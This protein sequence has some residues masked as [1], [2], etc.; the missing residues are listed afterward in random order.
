LLQSVGFEVLRFTNLDVFNDIPAVMDCIS[1]VV[2]RKLALPVEIPGTPPQA[3][4]GFCE[5]GT[6]LHG[7]VWGTLIEFSGANT[8]KQSPPANQIN[9]KRI[10]VL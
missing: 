9:L 4:V 5:W 8:C 1:N 3:G 7:I 2:L 6:S 10:K